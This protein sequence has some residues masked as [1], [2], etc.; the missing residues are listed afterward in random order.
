MHGPL[1]AYSQFLIERVIGMI[2]PTIHSRRH[3]VKNLQ[4]GIADYLRLTLLSRDPR[5][6]FLMTSDTEK[7]Q[8]VKNAC[9][10][11]RGHLHPDEEG[12]VFLRVPKPEKGDYLVSSVLPTRLLPAAW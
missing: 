12:S 4:N 6:K 10:V 1:W 7:R 9:V 2:M 8:P 5:F 3:P 11:P